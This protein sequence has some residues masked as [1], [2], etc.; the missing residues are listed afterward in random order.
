MGGG[1]YIGPCMVRYGGKMVDAINLGKSGVYDFRL[2]GLGEPLVER[3]RGEDVSNV[4]QHLPRTIPSCR[5]ILE[6][7][8]L[9]VTDSVS[10]GRE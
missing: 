8:S 4:I 3:V 1:T 6:N 7:G 9:I 2:A 10:R 5:D